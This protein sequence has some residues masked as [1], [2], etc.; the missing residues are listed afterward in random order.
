MLCV[1]DVDV[2]CRCVIQTGPRAL[3]GPRRASAAD[4]FFVNPNQLKTLVKIIVFCSLKVF[5]LELCGGLWYLAIVPFSEIS[6]SD[7]LSFMS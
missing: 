1:L 4:P 7:L 2:S 6:K 3:H 5:K